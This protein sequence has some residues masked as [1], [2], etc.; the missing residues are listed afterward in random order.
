[1]A[2]DGTAEVVWWNPAGLA[3]VRRSE[4][5]LNHSQSFVGTG[6]ALVVA[7]RSPF[8]VSALSANVLD[9]GADAVTLPDSFPVGDLFSRNVVAQLSHAVTVSRGVRLGVNY[10][11]QQFRVDC[12][13]ECPDFSDSSRTTSTTVDVGMQYD[14]PLA[15]PTKLGLAVRHLALKGIQGPER[16]Q[17]AQLHLGAVARYTIPKS[18]ATDATVAV[19][20]DLLDDLEF[21]APRPRFGVEFT[22][23]QRVSLR[24]GYVIEEQGTESGGASLGIGFTVR[25]LTIDFARNFS[26]LSADSGEP[27][28]FLALRLTF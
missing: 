8:G 9:L 20:A 4:A 1:V 28:A 21:H 11:V 10:K 12:S 17:T 3:G 14:L 18:V 7:V 19:S 5:S 6:D 2:L 25:R 13:G 27:P 24:G 16:R 22:W 26:G 23:E 15:L